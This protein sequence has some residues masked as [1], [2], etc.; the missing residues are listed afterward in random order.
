MKPES[1]DRTITIER[2]TS[3]QDPGS[4]EN[5][6]TWATLATV[7]ASK[8]DVSDRERIASAE[9]QAEITTRFVIR[10]SSTVADLNPKDR[11]VFDGRTYAISAVKEVGRREGVEISASARSD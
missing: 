2:F 11:V 6:E 4:G 5:V 7:S 1:F 9:V 3:K 8:K 10:Y